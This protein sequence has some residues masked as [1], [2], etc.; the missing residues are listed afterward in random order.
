MLVKKSHCHHPTKSAREVLNV[1]TTMKKKKKQFQ[2]VSTSL[3][4]PSHMTDA[5]CKQT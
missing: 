1:D 3:K 4:T 5:T 2:K